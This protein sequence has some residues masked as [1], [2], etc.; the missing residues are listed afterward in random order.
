MIV[1]QR[2]GMERPAG[3]QIWKQPLIATNQHIVLST[4][5][6]E[7]E[8]RDRVQSHPHESGVLVASTCDP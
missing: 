7:P 8:H 3:I 1:P 4:A 5:A 2:I 6:A